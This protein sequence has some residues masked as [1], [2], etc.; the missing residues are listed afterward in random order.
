[1]NHL[2]R[3]LVVLGLVATTVFS[4]VVLAAGMGILAPARLPIGYWLQDGLHLLTMPGRPERP[5]GMLLALGG[6]LV[7]VMLLWIEWRTVQRPER[8]IL[9]ST[10]P[11]GSVTLSRRGVERLAEQAA[12]EVFDVLDAQATVRGTDRLT[13]SCRASVTSDSH[14]PS[15]SDALKARLA[16]AIETHVGRPVHRVSIHTQLDPIRSGRFAPRVL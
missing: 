9:V 3:L 14:A 8:H 7:S 1:M 6:F 13:V 5:I 12:S 2:N 11:N 10:S 16:T 15:V 4:L